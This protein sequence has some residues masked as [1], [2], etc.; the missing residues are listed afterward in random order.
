MT[1]IL[2]QTGID[3]IPLDEFPSSN[4]SAFKPWAE[5]AALRKFILDTVALCSPKSVYLCNGSDGEYDWFCQELVRKGLF[6]P[7]DPKKRPNSFWCGSDPSD[8]ARV[9]EATFI[10]SPTEEIGRAHV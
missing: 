9:E 10:C 3:F 6:I 8:V 7:L 1:E 5:N 2:V 4:E